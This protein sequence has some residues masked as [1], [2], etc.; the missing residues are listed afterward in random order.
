ME[1]GTYE[2]GRNTW[3]GER[4]RI[5]PGTVIRDNCVIEDD[6]TLGANVYIDHGCV[7]RNDVSIGDHSAIG[8][9]CVIGEYQMDFFRERKRCRHPL[10]IGA[11]A[12]IRSGSILYSGS[13]I[14]DYFQTGHQVAVRE[15]ETIGNHVSVGSFC[16][17]QDECR[18]GDYARLHS[19][20]FCGQFSQV[21]ECAWIFP[22][23]VLT[24]D[25]TP[26][27]AREDWRGAIIRP[28]AIVAAN[29]VILPGI[30]IGRESLVG[31]G[32]VVT[33]RVEPYALVMGNPA[34]AR[35]DVRK[36]KNK[37]TGEAV[38]PWRNHFD[39][40]M[41]WEG[42]GFD[43]WSRSLD[44]ETKKRLFGDAPR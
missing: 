8:A 38:Y 14:G 13:V 10:K 35:G 7:I 34:E 5:G 2:I 12:M 37:E 41:P 20:V 17:I 29:A 40:A 43:A 27:S 24:N 26:P 4:V 16:D 1:K 23:A 25:R 36:L 6:A 44:E 31:A 9:G 42:A 11:H 33:K 30:E 18:I 28:F 39:R 15:D 22:H 3:I 19:D 32:S 21:G